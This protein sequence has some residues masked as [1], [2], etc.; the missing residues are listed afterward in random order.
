MSDF[1]ASKVAGHVLKQLI[2]EH[3]LSQDAFAYEFG[4]DVRTVSRYVNEGI[5]KLNV[6]QELAVFF[7]INIAY[8]FTAEESD[9]RGD[10]I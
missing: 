3:Y 7:H 6:L 2:K 5:N 4:A 1:N 10:E 8:F 9:V